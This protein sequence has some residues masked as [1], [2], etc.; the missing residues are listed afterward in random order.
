MSNFTRKLAV[1]HCHETGVVRGL[2]CFRCN[3]ALGNFGDN[4][5]GINKVVEYLQNTNTLGSAFK[6]REAQAAVQSAGGSS[7][8]GASAGEAMVAP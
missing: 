5:E 3:Q 8:E 4:L 1:D 6:G 2:L 7:S